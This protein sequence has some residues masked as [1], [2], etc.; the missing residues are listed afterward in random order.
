MYKFIVSVLVFCTLGPVFAQEVLKL[1]EAVRIMLENDYDIKVAEN[2]REMAENN[3]SVY[4]NNYLPQITGGGGANVSSQDVNTSYHD[5]TSKEV[6]GSNSLG[7]SASLGFNY[8]LFDGM[9]RSY[10]F[11]K[12]QELHHLSKLQV[13]YIIEGALINLFSAYYSVASLTESMQSL[14]QSV[15]ISKDRLLRAQYGAEYGKN[16]QLDVLNAQVDVNTDDINLINNRQALD[17]AKRDLNVL[18]GREVTTLFSID[19]T[20]FYAELQGLDALL[21]QA[22]EEN[23]RL[24]TARKNLELSGFNIKLLKTNRIPTLAL[25]GSYGWNDNHY[26]DQNL[27]DVQTSL[28]PQA[29]LSLSWSIFDGGQTKIGLQNAKLAA[30]SSLIQQEQAEKQVERD[31]INAYATYQNSIRV[32]E[33]EKENLKTNQLNFNRTEELY[34]LGQLTSIEFRQAQLNLLYAET[35]YKQSKYQSKLYELSLLRLTGNLLTMKF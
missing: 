31:V 32:L 17:N 25:S 2:N 5:G 16:T 7:Y 10:N 18:L 35:R 9:Y 11:E 30:E 34:K 23:T 29:A 26:N 14:K 13:R 6:N 27:I 22:Q 8:T 19:T 20:V 1:D 33:S 28:G 24:L 3:T 21:L 15:D 12:S 4:A